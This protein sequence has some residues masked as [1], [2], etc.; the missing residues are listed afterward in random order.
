MSRA[1][2]PRVQLVPVLV[3]WDC[4]D[5]AHVEEWLPPGEDVR[6][7]LTLAIGLAGE[8]ATDNFQVCVATP[9]GLGSGRGQLLLRGGRRTPPIVVNPYRWEAVRAEISRRLDACRGSDWREVQDRLRTQFLWE[10]ETVR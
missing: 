5:I 7:W 6:Y 2:S 1:R 9:A 3:H 4:A 8:G 10:Y